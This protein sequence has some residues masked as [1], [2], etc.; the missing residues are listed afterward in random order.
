VRFRRSRHLI[1]YWEDQ[2]LVLHNFATRRSLAVPARTAELLDFFGTSRSV[3]DVVAWLA[4]S[5]TEARKL[6]RRLVDATLLQRSDG[7][8]RSDERAMAAWAAWNPA[9]GFFHSA[10]RNIQF[11][12]FFEGARQLDR[13]ARHDP[14]PRSVKRYRG[15]VTR[16]LPPISGGTEFPRVLL[17]RRTWRQ[18]SRRPVLMEDL[19]TLLGLTSGVQHWA[20]APGHGEL[21]L[22][23]SPSGGALHP[24]EV[25]VCARRVEGLKPGLYHYASDA[26]CL[27]RVAAQARPA[28]VQRYLPTQYWYGGAAALIFF[29]GVFERYLWKYSYAR[30]YRAVLIEAG[31]QCQTF[32]LAATWLGLAPFCSMALADSAIEGDLGLDG[33]SEAVLYAAGVGA[34]PDGPAVRSHPLGTRP[35]TLRPNPHMTMPAPRSSVRA[36]GSRV[37]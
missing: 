25:Y 26:H 3:Q 8:I 37:P 4:I 21:P 14:P 23:T 34:R 22:K 17:A 28:R 35:M 33:I 7:K 27:E 15:V 31:H 13:K 10:T 29:T 9:A 36:R 19:G 5:T 32:C 12:E 24:I 20:L 6:I 11:V 2:Q 1:S 18:F 30:A 16:A